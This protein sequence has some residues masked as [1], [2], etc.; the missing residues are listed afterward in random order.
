ML[1]LLLSPVLAL[2]PGGESENPTLPF[3]RL[4]EEAA[5]PASPWSGDVNFGFLL[6]E[7]N[8]ETFTTNFNANAVREGE[9]DRW[10]LGLFA[11]YGEQTTNDVTTKNIADVGGSAKYDYKVNEKLYYYGNGYVK[12]DDIADLDIRYIL[13]AGAGYTFRDSEELSWSGE[14]GLSYVAEEYDVD[15]P[16]DDSNETVAVRLA[17]T[18]GYKVSETT[19]FDQNTELFPSLE[20][21][22][23][24]YSR[25][26]SRLTMS[27]TDTWKGVLQ[28]ILEYDDMPAPGAAKADHRLIFTLGWTFGK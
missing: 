11:N 3:L 1:A 28:Y 24:F 26:D 2:A 6:T 5:E 21:S 22:D 8:S 17:S 14:A 27:I 4:Q 7:G 25:F 16:L 10:T 15:P 13:G 23:D 9:R 12:T 20:D 19:R 18:L